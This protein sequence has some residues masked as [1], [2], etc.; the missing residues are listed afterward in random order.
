MRGLFRWSRKWWPGLIPLAVLWGL[1]AWY[2]TVPM[3]QNL[4]AATAAALKNDVLDKTRIDLAGRDVTF[5]ADAFSE[6]G[7]RSALTSVE[8]VPGVRLVNDRTR[9]VPEAKPY[10]WT[11]QR[12]VVRVTLGGSTPLPAIKARLSEAAKAALNGVEVVDRTGF[13]RGA[14][15]RFD[16]AVLLLIEQVARLKEGK[17]TLSD[18][19]VSLSGMA[20]ELGGRE[21]IW[22][23]LRNLPE[24][25]S[26]AAND[27]AAPSYVFQAN[28]DPV[29]GTLTLSGYVPDNKVHAAL[30]EAA[31]RKFFGEKVTDNLK[32]SIGAPKGFAEMVTRALGA[33]SRLSTGS[34]EVAD[35]EVKLSGDALFDGA[36]NQI[37]QSLAKELPEG[38]KAKAEIS[39]KPAAAPVDASVCQRLFSEVL[40]QG[41]IRFES[42]SA[43]INVDSAGLL[44]RLAE[45]ALRCPAAGIDIIGHT[46]GD[47]D[48]AANQ[49]L[50]EARAK[51]VADYLVKT[52]LPADR[53]KTSGQ[54]SSV[55]L[56]D[57]STEEGKAKNRRI[58]FL[59]R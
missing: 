28:K 21:A 25:Y 48:A 17:V 16:A 40:G 36:A 20:R 15:A 10:V 11:A 38:W 58:D 22:A 39:V 55:P 30:V 12:D 3:E 52:G 50:S 45:I 1:A 59:V 49:A 51:A 5:S 19:A 57:N 24:G 35:R 43:T 4:A 54:G 42:G 8:G 27:I 32:A 14:P 6:E 31:E 53:F 18:K 7:R 44:D 37:R 29:G 56:A 9:L 33:L 47:G 23:S 46:D 2:E 13:A 34:L 41:R 26:V